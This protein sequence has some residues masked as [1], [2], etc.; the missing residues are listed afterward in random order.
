MIEI[1]RGS[2]AFG[3][4][5]KNNE[6]IAGDVRLRTEGASVALSKLHFYCQGRLTN[7]LHTEK[8]ITTICTMNVLWSFQV[9]P[10]YQSTISEESRR[11]L[12][13]MKDIY[14]G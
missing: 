3:D 12:S 13:R 2:F 10:R 1:S 8:V 5:M 9:Y 4:G 6:V 11:I 14:L 7:T